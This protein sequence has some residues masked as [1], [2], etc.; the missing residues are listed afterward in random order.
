VR[1][2]NAALLWTDRPQFSYS[3][4]SER[5]YSS[6]RVISESESRDILFIADD[7][8]MSAAINAAI[9]R[10]HVDGAL[11]GACLMMGQAGTD[12][13]IELAREHESLQIG[14][15]LH[16]N[17]SQPLTVG[18]W[19]WGAS[20]A[21][22]GLAIAGLPRARTLTRTEM[23]RQWQAFADTG[24][25]CRFAN[26]HHHLHWHPFVRRQLVETLSADRRFAGWLR[27][28]RP[29]RFDGDT[30]PAG[31][32]L[33][34]RLL[35]APQRSRMQIRQSTTLWGLDRAFAMDAREVAAILPTLGAG[36]H[37]FM[38]HPRPGDDDADTRCLVE[39][40][41]VAGRA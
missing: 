24:L 18:E 23:L 7:F 3:Y 27:W 31:Y 41:S 17:D 29:C 19:P 40:R 22:A 6:G 9:L 11:H 5:S 1:S 14:W 4:D 12:E 32:G 39:L 38:F 21:R 26:A 25:E 34:D 10:A 16:L 35:Q 36:L 30:P 33:I 20:P 2:I 15:H 37:E 28:G 8:G 13:A